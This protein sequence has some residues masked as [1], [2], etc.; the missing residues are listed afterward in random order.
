MSTDPSI[1]SVCLVHIINEVAYPTQLSQLVGPTH[2]IHSG[3]DLV[4][5]QLTFYDRQRIV[6]SVSLI[7]VHVHFKIPYI[8]IVHALFDTALAL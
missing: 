7:G 5:V 3:H 4:L 2:N 8:S 1:L 6:Q